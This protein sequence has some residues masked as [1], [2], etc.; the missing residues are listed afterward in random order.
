MTRCAGMA[1]AA[2]LIGG[3]V[4]RD[5]G[6]AS[7]SRDHS[8]P[9]SA[10]P[11][12]APVTAPLQTQ[13]L[14]LGRSVNGQSITIELFNPGP[15]PIFIMGGIHG[16]ERA[17]VDIA[18]NLAELLHEQPQLTH[19]KPIAILAV[20]NPDG[21]AANTRTNGRN[22]DLNRNFPAHNF[23]EATARSRTGPYPMSEPETQAIM[24]ALN[25]LEPSMIISIHSITRGRECNNYD[26]PNG[27][28]IADLMSNYNG[29]PSVGYIGYPTPGS[30]GTYAGM[31][32]AIPMVTLEV[33]RSDSGEQAWA[34]N[35]EALLAVIREP[36]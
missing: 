23:H 25:M 26:G 11:T 35:R 16:D 27:K 15:N 20:A 22:V 3:C 28:W 32:K 21:Y 8:S 7:I 4:V 36:K 31:D 18:Q 5:S 1:L 17:S 33:P 30:L 9:T 2:M 12:T 29:Y 19:G 10:A 13:T 34:N 24:T 6:R 14:Q